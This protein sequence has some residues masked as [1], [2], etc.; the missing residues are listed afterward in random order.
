MVYVYAMNAANL[1]DPLEY[2]EIMA[3]LPEER[4][5]K[6]RRY[7]QPRDRKLSLGAGLLLKESLARH[8]FQDSCIKYSGNEK[9]EIEGIY[10][11]LSHSHHMVVCAVGNQEV[12]CDVE[13]IA[14]VQENIAERF[15]TKNEI[16]YL[17][18]FSQEDRKEEFF[19][20]WT[21]KESYMKMTGEGM[22]LALD[23]FEIVI[24]DPIKVFRDGERGSC[25]IKE[26]T[27]PGYKLSVCAKEAEFSE[28]E[29]LTDGTE[30]G[31]KKTKKVNLQV[32]I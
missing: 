28:L 8:G 9:P 25:F 16:T 11:N 7:R 3:G 20:L 19:R 12:G 10:F 27:I 30:Y 5:E 1:P 18:S 13:E 15:F 2:P 32:M 26:Y 22:C 17:H 29:L 24:K 14:D 6:I 23:R 31:M 4:K 21:M